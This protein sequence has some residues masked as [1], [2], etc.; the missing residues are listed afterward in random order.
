MSKVFN[1]YG[2]ATCVHSRKR[3]NAPWKVKDSCPSEGKLPGVKDYEVP[4]PLICMSCRF[5]R[6][7]SGKKGTE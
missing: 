2:Y 5:Y 7:D 1:H 4:Y 3:Q 6:R